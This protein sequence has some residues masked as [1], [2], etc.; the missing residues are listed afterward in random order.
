MDDDI[1][2]TDLCLRSSRVEH[3]ATEYE[4]ANIPAGTPP[5]EYKRS[6]LASTLIFSDLRAHSKADDVLSVP[7]FSCALNGSLVLTEMDEGCG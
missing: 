3:I 5:F 6:G 4:S 7:S 2:T 1:E